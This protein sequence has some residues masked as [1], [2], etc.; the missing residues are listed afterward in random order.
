MDSNL[1]EHA[2]MQMTQSIH[3]TVEHDFLLAQTMSSHYEQSQSPH[4]N[5]C[6]GYEAVPREEQQT[7]PQK[8]KLLNDY[9][10]TLE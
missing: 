5:T 7:P 8:I 10:R 9:I 3:E 4:Q 6:V 2:G 1:S